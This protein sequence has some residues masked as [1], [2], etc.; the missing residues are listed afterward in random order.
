MLY[1]LTKR[2][3]S[4]CSPGMSMVIIRFSSLEVS[5]LDI[6]VRKLWRK[7]MLRSKWKQ[8][9]IFDNNLPNMSQM[10]KKGPRR[11][12]YQIKSSFLLYFTIRYYDRANI[13]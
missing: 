4:Y 13:Q 11:L 8:Q 7:G 12:N 1:L 6:T 9:H 5:V 3:K 10:S 2:P